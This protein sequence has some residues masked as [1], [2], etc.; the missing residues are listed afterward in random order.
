MSKNIA[1]SVTVTAFVVL[2]VA[3]CSKPAS[4]A[5]N[6]A[7][8]AVS[9]SVAAAPAATAQI[10]SD[11]L[12]DLIAAHFADLLPPNA[13]R[14]AKV[15]NT[16]TLGGAAPGQPRLPQVRVN[17]SQGADTTAQTLDMFRNHN[18]LAQDAP[19]L[20]AGAYAML[21]SNDGAMAKFSVTTAKA[22]RLTIIEVEPGHP[23]SAADQDKA[24]ADAKALLAAL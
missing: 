17:H 13:A 10:G 5:D 23:L 18:P 19:T 24:L 20:G 15:S 22:G 6:P 1:R 7:A 3:A 4:K 14:N 8:A 11:Q 2:S 21:T 16:C 12:C 9:T